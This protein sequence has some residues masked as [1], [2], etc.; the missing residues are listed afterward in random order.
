MDLALGHI[1]FP[2]LRH[3]PQPL[4][5]KWLRDAQ[6]PAGSGRLPARRYRQP[7]ATMRTNA[8][9]ARSGRPPR[10]TTTRT[11]DGHCDA[12]TRAACA[13]PG[14]SSRWAGGRLRVGV[15][16]RRPDG[17]AQRALF[18]GA[19]RG[20]LHRPHPP[21]I[22]FRYFCAVPHRT[23]F[24]RLDRPGVVEVDHG[25]ELVGQPR[26]E[27]VAEAF[28]LGPVDDADRAL[29]PRL[30]QA[31][32]DVASPRSGSRS[33]P[34]RRTRGSSP[35]SCPRSAGRTRLRSAGAVPVGRGRARCRRGW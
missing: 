35:R 32:R 27:V 33:A 11:I 28:G 31:V 29:E 13:V 17:N 19:L 14:R 22:G 7:W 2:R 6:A 18:D 23:A 21:R 24:Q 8:S 12:A 3:Y 5:K 1:G 25:V 30:A 34:A 20:D 4:S 9:H 10:E 26:V 15:D 16:P